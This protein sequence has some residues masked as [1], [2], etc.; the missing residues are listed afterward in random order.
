M[1][2]S[3]TPHALWLTIV[4]LALLAPSMASAGT[5]GALPFTPLGGVDEGAADNIGSLVSSELDIAGDWELVIS[6]TADEITDGCG[7]NQSCW[8]AFG[9]GEGHTH[10][11]TG[12]VGKAGEDYEVKT[13]LYEVGSGRLV[14]EVVKNVS[15]KPGLLLDQIPA[16]AAELASGEK[17][18]VKDSSSVAK[19]TKPKFEEPE[20]DDEDEDEDEVAE[21]EDSPKWMNRD[22]RG[23]LI[24]EEGYD[25]DE[26]DPFGDLGDEDLDLDELDAGTQRKK[27]D[28]RDERLAREAAREAEEEAERRR[29]AEERER[30]EIEEERRARAEER[31]RED[32]R[33]AEEEERRRR[34]DEERQARAERERREELRKRAAAREKE[35]EEERRAEEEK[36]RR[37]EERRAE[38]E[39]R[40]D[41]ERRAAA[42]ERRK[43]ERRKAAAEER[44]E[45]ERQAADRERRD[46]E[47]RASAAEERREA[48]RR[49]ASESRR[50]EERRRVEA[51]RRDEERRSADRRRA[52]V[53]RYEDEDEDDAEFSLRSAVVDEDDGFMIEDDDPGFVIE[54]EDE[55][56]GF[57]MEEDDDEEDLREGEI[58]TYGEEEEEESAPVSRRRDDYDPYARARGFDEKDTSDDD[59]DEE[60]EPR[61]RN[62]DRRERTTK[63]ERSYERVDRRSDEDDEDEDEDEDDEGDFDRLDRDDDDDRLAYNA[64]GYPDRRRSYDDDDEVRARPSSDRRTDRRRD[65]EDDEYDVSDYGDRGGSYSSSSRA[66]ARTARRGPSDMKWAAFRVHAG[67]ANYYLHFGSFGLD[68][69]V[70][71]FEKASVDFGVDFWAVGLTVR[72]PL[73]DEEIQEVHTLPNFSL[74]GSWRADFHK[75]L[76]PFVG[77]DFTTTVYATVRRGAPDGPMEPRASAG[78]MIKGGLDVLFGGRAGIHATVKGGVMH[79]EDI[80]ELVSAEW[81]ATQGV[82]TF[83]FG[84]SLRI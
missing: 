53:D 17:V 22:R 26:D 56:D 71:I 12:T 27:A 23:R 72:D 55:D 48:D 58:I 52:E 51:D 47:R 76:K 43:E 50:D 9:K 31:R 29:I 7:Q 40:K 77:A 39:R 24:R 6:A 70:L 1:R 83:N 69:S 33:R 54:E 18:E 49:A 8:Q 20:F 5:A 79:A 46:E 11:I 4:A 75:I 34:D 32:E 44:R 10:V 45:E 19:K 74:G 36:R 38:A 73:S 82:L 14:R 30:R 81:G 28:A 65:D 59:D 68:A 15:R 64:D 25:E 66:R 84:F 57:V 35:E 41:E 62:Y 37:D 2:M 61:E 42:D 21:D 3:T 80:S 60:Y 16:L 63:R 13:Q 78:V 67:Y